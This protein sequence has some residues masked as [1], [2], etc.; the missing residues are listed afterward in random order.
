MSFIR[1][2][3]PAITRVTQVNPN[4]RTMI[5]PNRMHL[6]GSRMPQ[7]TFLATFDESNQ[8]TDNWNFQ[9]AEIPLGSD[10]F[11]RVDISPWENVNAVLGTSQIIAG[12][13]VMTNAIGQAEPARGRLDISGEADAGKWNRLAI[14]VT[15]SGASGAQVGVSNNLDTSLPYRDS[16]EISVVGIYEAVFPA[17][18]VNNY[19]FA[20]NYLETDSAAAAFDNYALNYMPALDGWMLNDPSL[21]DI[22]TGQAVV[23]RNGG[24]VDDGIEIDVVV[25]PQTHYIASANATAVA[26]A[27]YLSVSGISPQVS[28]IVT[29]PD[30]VAGGFYTAAASL[31]TISINGANA[32]D[33]VATFDWVQLEQVIA[34]DGWIPKS[35]ATIAEIIGGRAS[36]SG[37]IEAYITTSFLTEAALHYFGI[38][39]YTAESTSQA[40]AAVGTTP[41]GAEL[42]SAATSSAVEVRDFYSFTATSGLSYLTLGNGTD[43]GAATFDGASIQRNWV[44][45]GTFDVDLTGWNPTAPV[46]GSSVTWESGACR[47]IRVGGDLAFIEQLGVMTLGKTYQLLIETT[48]TS[49]VLV[50][51]LGDV[52]VQQEISTDG[53]SNI[54]FVAQAGIDLTIY[55]NEGCNV[56]ADNI[57]LREITQ[58]LGVDPSD[59]PFYGLPTYE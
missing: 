24:V 43:T 34:L 58:P 18:G 3:Q 56:L 27:A 45:N 49:G 31:V 37:E 11:N 33:A 59:A 38:V 32:A 39:V 1:A 30:V 4:G 44:A 26:P 13:L 2:R 16:K 29:T 53:V 41:G 36:V 15:D 7:W 50:V 5:V 54:E 20:G 8:V 10:N 23:D 52:S 40:L 25:S 12:E 46:G 47:I 55:A 42:T 17:E 14:D 22:V 21:V 6:G 48:F 57:L 51:W 9:D 28:E 35:T 19:V